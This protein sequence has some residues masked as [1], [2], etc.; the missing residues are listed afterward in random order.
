MGSN[1]NVINK[2]TDGLKHECDQFPLHSS[3]AALALC[4]QAEYTM[5]PLTAHSSNPYPKYN[6]NHIMF[7]KVTKYQGSALS[8]TQFIP[9]YL[10]VYLLCNKGCVIFFQM[11]NHTSDNLQC[12][13]VCVCVCK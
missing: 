5:Y 1:I 8:F 4:N 11:Y 13:S 2:S 12:G 3:L 7:Y 6:P 9:Q 10:K